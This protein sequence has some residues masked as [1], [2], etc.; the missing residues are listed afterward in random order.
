MYNGKCLLFIWLNPHS[1]ELKKVFLFKFKFNL[2]INSKIY[3]INIVNII[4]ILNSSN[5]IL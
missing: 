1:I 4:K 2:L 5:I 3:L